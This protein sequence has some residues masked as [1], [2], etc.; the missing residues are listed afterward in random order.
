MGNAWFRYSLL[1]VALGVTT[2]VV[3]DAYGQS[4]LEEKDEFGARTPMHAAA[5]SGFATYDDALDF[6]E[7]SFAF[8]DYDRV[9]R[10]LEPWLMPTPVDRATEA[11]VA[12]GYA[13]LGASAW[14]EG[15]IEEA[16]VI[17]RAGLRQRHTMSLDPLV[18][19]PE[20]VHFFRELREQMQPELTQNRSNATDNVVYIE[21]RVAQH[22]RWVSMLPFGYGMFVNGE[23]EWGI[24]YAITEVSLLGVSASLFWANYAQRTASDDPA[25]PLGYP[26][27]RRA[28]TRRRV[29]IG[30][31]AAFLGVMFI[32]VV[33][34]ALIHNREQR[35]QYR[36]LTGP[37]EGFDAGGTPSQRSRR[38]QIRVTPLLDLSN[39][40]PH[41]RR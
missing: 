5:K 36:T 17:F 12:D 20:L 21:S 29:H 37:P 10:V 35:V 8:G 15:R 32:N 1:A 30:T 19:P 13:W 3:D 25:N 41:P 9:I 6:A 38:W 7:N 28:E 31:G 22:P 14:F 39:Q 2:L 26:D 27:A 23:S 4:V 24:A 11:I 18:F 40:P 33:H 16:D 34:G